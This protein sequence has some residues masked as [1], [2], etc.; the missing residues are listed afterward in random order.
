[1]V[2]RYTI[3]FFLPFNTQ[4]INLTILYHNYLLIWKLGFLGWFT[5]SITNAQFILKKPIIVCRTAA[6]LTEI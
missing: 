3:N 1:M 5:L 6:K 2:S 4:V